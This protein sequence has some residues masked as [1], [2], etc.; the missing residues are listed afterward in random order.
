MERR[1]IYT[2]GA[3]AAGIALAVL[4]AGKTPKTASANV[5]V[6]SD[7]NEVLE[8]LA[9]PASSSSS[10]SSSSNNGLAVDDPRRLEIRE[11]KRVLD[12]NPQEVRVAVRL[13][14]LNIQLARETSDPRYLGHAQAALA[15]WWVRDDQM[16]VPA[17]VL[18]LRATIEQ[19]LHDFDSAL[20]HLNNALAADPE[21][22]QA[23]LTRAT[24][25]TVL[26]RYEEA[27]RSCAMI[28]SASLARMV[29]ETQIESLTGHAK[30]AYAKLDAR[31][32]GEE[33]TRLDEKAWA[34]SVM[35]EYAVRFG[36]PSLAEKHFKQALAMTPT[37]A[38]T[39]N[40]L[41]DLLI[42]AGGSSRSA[43]VVT[44]L[45]GH[46]NDDGMLLRLAIAE[47]RAKLPNASAHIQMLEDRFDASRARGD[48]VHR[49]E[50]ARFWLDLKDDPTKAL[51]L[52]KAN[53]QVQKE[54]WDARILLAAA[55]AAKSPDAAAP[56]IAFLDQHKLEDPSIAR[57]RRAAP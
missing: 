40:A 16:Y 43:E 46:E 12:Q 25:L 52:A 38:Y 50:E 2:L 54:P 10:S 17:P 21:D 56:V 47:R 6:P 35:G 57:L 24:I 28:A 34:D 42:D 13:A 23:W 22:M 45:A 15:P 55:R 1:R 41:A 5:R 44:L 51:E 37:D 49:R 39:R 9:S 11:L 32:R 36:D 27:E 48:V 8:V 26:A 20:H 29:C 33:T 14:R 4:I 3:L 30:E 7:P 19:S 18:V 31:L 53:W